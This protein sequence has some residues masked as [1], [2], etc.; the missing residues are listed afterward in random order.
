MLISK[1]YADAMS[2]VDHIDWVQTLERVQA[3]ITRPEFIQVANNPFIDTGRKAELV[4]ACFKKIAPEQESLIRELA[5]NSRFDHTTEILEYYQRSQQLK[6]GKIQVTI[7]TAQ[8][9]TPKQKKLIEQFARTKLTGQGEA[10]FEYQINEK[11]IGGFTLRYN[12]YT[13]DKSIATRLESIS[14][15]TQGA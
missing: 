3:I 7:T 14:Y 4:I 10:L 8:K 6:A 13:I 5:K 2:Q 15:N 12:D 9:P 11:I 1:Q